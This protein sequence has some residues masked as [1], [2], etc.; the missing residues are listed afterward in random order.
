MS[1]SVLFSGL[2]R[3]IG[4][5]NTNYMCLMEKRK[6]PLPHS[7][8]LSTSLRCLAALLFHR[9]AF[10]HSLTHTL[11]SPWQGARL[12]LIGSHLW[13]YAKINGGARRDWLRCGDARTLGG[14][15]SCRWNHWEQTTYETLEMQLCFN[16]WNS[17]HILKGSLCTVLSVKSN[18][19]NGAN[20][21]EGP[22]EKQTSSAHW[23]M[24]PLDGRT[25]SSYSPSCSVMMMMKCWSSS[26]WLRSDRWFYLDAKLHLLHLNSSGH[27]C[28]IEVN[29]KQKSIVHPYFL[30]FFFG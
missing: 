7:V 16:F 5:E 18:D 20:R 21:C 29:W 12:L 14:G 10:I 17:V 13:D 25:L 6:I 3:W 30:W 15:T 2:T 24:S 26:Y 27:R 22:E 1:Y 4:A 19:G 11:I 28:T 9:P 8:G 23:H